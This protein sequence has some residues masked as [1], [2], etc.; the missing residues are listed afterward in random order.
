MIAGMEL[1]YISET[2]LYNYIKAG[3]NLPS[4]PDLILDK[5]PYYNVALIYDIS[6]FISIIIVIIYIVHKK[7]YNRVPFMLLMYGIIEIV[8]GFFIILTPLGNPALFIGSDGLFNGFSKYELGNYPS[9]HVG[10]MFLLLLMVKS[11]FYKG[12]L[13]LCLLAI[14]ISLLLAH[15]HYS[16][17]IFGGLLFAYAIYSFGNKHFKMFEL[18]NINAGN[19]KNL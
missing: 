11:R 1:N 5:L 7:D 2:C 6:S 9:G 12:L 3:N 19:I 15:A 14:I 4:L 8:R 13:S 18:D 10:F 16:I 17:D